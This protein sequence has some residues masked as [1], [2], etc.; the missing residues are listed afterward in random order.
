VLI[1]GDCKKRLI[2]IKGSTRYWTGK[3]LLSP[4]KFAFA[5]ESIDQTT[6]DK[7]TP[8]LLTIPPQRFSTMMCSP[9]NIEQND[10]HHKQQDAALA[11][12][13]FRCPLTGDVMHDPVA[14]PCGHS[15]ERHA[16]QSFIN[17]HGR[18]CPVDGESFD[19]PCDVKP[20]CH[21]QWEILF[22]Q[23]QQRK[24]QRQQV[25][26]KITV[27]PMNIA[28]SESTATDAA[29]N[30]PSCPASSYV[31]EPLPPPPSSAFRVDT[32]PNRPQRR[33]SI[34]CKP[35]VVAE[36]K[37]TSNTATA[38][39]SLSLP[40]MRPA[41][42]PDIS[43]PRGSMLKSGSDNSLSNCRK[44]KRAASLRRRRRLSSRKDERHDDDA[45]ANMPF[46]L[47]LSPSSV[48]QGDHHN[49]SRNRILAIYAEVMAIVE[50]SSP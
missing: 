43:S 9:S 44:P 4:H 35:V 12:M 41:F 17:D 33:K 31:F 15:F 6:D 23:R 16:M 39:C 20:N 38:A 18:S 21:L 19:S 47:T 46:D 30:P 27:Q 29:D 40:P 3:S 45:N 25:E 7:Y 49:V 32:P 13:R 50:Q 22:W 10:R 1:C 42:I 37:A 11:E 8:T 48:I 2:N 28:L 14:L 36:Y 24:K 34:D 26:E 5:A